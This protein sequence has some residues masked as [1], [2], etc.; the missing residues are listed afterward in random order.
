MP[1]DERSLAVIALVNRLVD[2]GVEPLRSAELW[3]L[4]ERV[5]DPT[6]LLGRGE[7]ELIGILGGRDLALRVAALL[8]GG[9]GLAL[10]L[11]ALQ[12]RGIWTL[13]VF[14]DGYPEE[15]RRSLGTGAPA[16]LHGA[17]DPSLA[18]RPGLGLVGVPSDPP[19]LAELGPATARLAADHRISVVTGGEETDL[20]ATETAVGAGG[21]VV[22]VPAGPLV[23]LLARAEMRR[24]ILE[25]DLCVLSPYP[26]D[27]RWS[28]GAARGRYRVLHGLSRLSF[29][30]ST[31]E[32][33]TAWSGARR[34]VD[35][36]SGR[37]AVWSGAGATA[38][39]AALI[40]AGATPVGKLSRLS[41]LIDGD[42]GGG[43]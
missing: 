26:P 16:L 30:V 41:S 35:N 10:R 22:A 29:V 33:D 19:H 34:A 6:T 37:V 25:S 27:T 2:V 20:A 18:A 23:D 13:T 32:G 24:W 36:G 11:Q 38:G 1:S 5:T 3:D 28:P 40:A 21:R 8:D 39:N 43:S 15:L 17:G 14:D 9:V 4:L 12:D 31:V 7:D 42:T